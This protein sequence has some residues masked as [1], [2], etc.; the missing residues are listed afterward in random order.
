MAEIKDEAEA[1]EERATTKDLSE[2]EQIRK[3]IADTYTAVRSSEINK[4]IAGFTLDHYIDEAKRKIK[5][6]RVLRSASNPNEGVGTRPSLLTTLD[7][8]EEDFN[9]SY[10]KAKEMAE[11][12]GSAPPEE[13][14]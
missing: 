1:F 2:S 14:T 7:K 3:T 4:T 11:K 9:K 12:V 5:E 13:P 10:E 6:E 8:L